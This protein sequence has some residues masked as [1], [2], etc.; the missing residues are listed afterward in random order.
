[1][2]ESY[3]QGRASQVGPE[4]CVDGRK[5]GGEALTGAGFPPKY[6]REPYTRAGYAAAKIVIPGRRRRGSRRKATSPRTT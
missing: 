2:K 3:D 5:T 4:S 1:M 6:R